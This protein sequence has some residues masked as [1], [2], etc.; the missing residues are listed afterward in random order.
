MGCAKLEGARVEAVSL[1]PEIGMVVD[2]RIN[3]HG[4]M[5]GKADDV[6]RLEGSSPG[7]VMAD[8]R[9]P[10]GSES[11][12]CTQRGSSGTWENLLFPCKSPE[13]EVYRFTKRP[14]VSGWLS[15]F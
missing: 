12:A 5:R 13:D 11:R 4:N 2:N 10:P 7:V 6:Q 14:G 8:Y 1:N 3:F 15:T 9:T